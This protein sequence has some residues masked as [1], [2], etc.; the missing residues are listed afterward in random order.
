MN[1]VVRNFSECF[2]GYKLSVGKDELGLKNQPDLHP[3]I[4]LE[5]KDNNAPVMFF[6][7]PDW[8]QPVSNEV[9]DENGN[10]HIVNDKQYVY[11]EVIIAF[12][13]KGYDLNN[14]LGRAQSQEDKDMFYKKIS[15]AN[16]MI[17]AKG[18][19]DLDI[20][21]Y[22]GVGVFV[23]KKGGKETIIYF[24]INYAP[25]KKIYYFIDGNHIRFETKNS[26]NSLKVKVLYDPVRMPCLV[27]ET[28][29]YKEYEVKFV[30][31]GG[32]NHGIIPNEFKGMKLFVDFGGSSE[33]IERNRSVYLLVCEHI[34]KN[35]NEQIVNNRVIESKRICPYCHNEIK[36]TANYYGGMYCDGEPI[37]PVKFFTEKNKVKKNFIVCKE[38]KHC[39][40]QKIYRILPDDIF[41]KR[42]YRIAVLGK[43]RS[44]KTTYLSRLF[45]VG[46]A[47]KSVNINP[48]EMEFFRFYNINTSFSQLYDLSGDRTA[49]VPVYI[50]RGGVSYFV[51]KHAPN[52]AKIYHICSR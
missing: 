6:T 52:E 45:N 51:G 49:T 29:P 37:K 12:D 8:Y 13:P 35:N 9:V 34:K 18:R 5:K 24:A 38:E 48:E 39:E 30:K 27:D 40:T 44:G 11:E 32:K 33:E 10:K 46:S 36:M 28:G 1:E 31:S 16:P 15:Y 26:L 17:K 41:G 22:S 19:F 23:L 4:F 3:R 14:L 21:E 20:L 2:F 7:F 47:E 25:R 50:P 43:A 42:N